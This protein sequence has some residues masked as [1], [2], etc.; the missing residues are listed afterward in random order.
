MVV[1]VTQQRVVLVLAAEQTARPVAAAAMPRTEVAVVPAP[2]E[3][4]Q[5]TRIRVGF[6]G[7]VHISSFLKEVHAQAEVEVG[8]DHHR[9]RQDRM[10]ARNPGQ[11]PKEKTAFTRKTRITNLAAHV[12]VAQMKLFML[13][14][15]LDHPGQPVG[16]LV[17]IPVI[18]RPAPVPAGMIV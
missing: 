3:P 9:P 17:A 16:Q 10:I 8:L 5:Q 6:L 4:A 15:L 12:R 14:R 13:K 1:L 7:S 18:L 2:T 11:R